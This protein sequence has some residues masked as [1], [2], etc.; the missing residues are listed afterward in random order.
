MR[1]HSVFPFLFLLILVSS[2]PAAA[3]PRTRWLDARLIEYKITGEYDGRFSLNAT[4]DAHATDR[5]EIDF[6]TNAEG[7]LQGEVTIRNFK[8]AVSDLQPVPAGCRAPEL[9]GEVEF[10]TLVSFTCMACNETI[11]AYADPEESN[12][13]SKNMTMSVAESEREYPAM[14]VGASCTGKLSVPAHTDTDGE[15]VTIPGRGEYMMDPGQ[16]NTNERQLDP[17]A[18]TITVQKS[19][20]TWTYQATPVGV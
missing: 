15:M 12:A 2:V 13:A 18:G 14:V 19:G 20:W 6:T 3:D 11:A 1:A 16:L 8:S 7:D 4:G 17:E 9:H 5:V 10:Y